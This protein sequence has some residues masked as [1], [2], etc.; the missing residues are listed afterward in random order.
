MGGDIVSKE[1]DRVPLAKALISKDVPNRHYAWE[2]Q[3]RL[4]RLTSPGDIC[5]ARLQ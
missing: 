5:R 3:V 1:R 4:Y 2:E